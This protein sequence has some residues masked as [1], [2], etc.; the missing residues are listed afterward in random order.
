M[1]PPFGMLFEVLLFDELLE[2]LLFDELF[3]EFVE[4]RWEELCWW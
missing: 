1:L 2:L 4:L 3:I